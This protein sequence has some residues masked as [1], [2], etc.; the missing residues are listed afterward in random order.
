MDRMDEIAL[1]E[2]GHPPGSA[3]ASPV[4]VAPFARDSA[5]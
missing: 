4:G 2:P 3:I 5:A 1:P